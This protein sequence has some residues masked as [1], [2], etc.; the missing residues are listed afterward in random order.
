MDGWKTLGAIAPT[1]LSD[2][3]KQVHWACQLLSGVAD[4]QHGPTDDD[5][6][7]NVFVNSLG[8]SGREFG[9]QVATLNFDPISVS[10]SNGDRVQNFPLN[11]STLE[12]AHSWLSRALS[13]EIRFRDYEIPEHSVSS[14]AVFDVGAIEGQE[15]LRWFSNGTEV[16]ETIRMDYPGTTAVAIWPHHFDVGAILFIDRDSSPAQAK[17]I[18]IGLSPGDDHYDEPYFYV[19]PWPLP[20][21]ALLP[22]LP[23][24][25]FWR[26]GDFSGRGS[27]GEPNRECG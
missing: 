14:G 16:L 26:S 24:G 21:G 8:L 3:R 1:S 2:T 27:D 25:G 23:S 4:A 13:C 7:T 10:L 19:T 22:D 5:S 15:L 9:G 18:G 17:Q 12:Q 11:G 6:H 20:E